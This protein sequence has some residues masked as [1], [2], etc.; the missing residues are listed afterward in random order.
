MNRDKDK[1]LAH[2]GHTFERRAFEGLEWFSR[3]PQVVGGRT[4]ELT[5]RLRKLSLKSGKLARAASRPMSVAVFGASQAG[6]SFMTGQ[7]ISPTK[8]PTKVVF[9]SGSETTTMDYGTRINPTGGKET[10]G[11]VTRFS[12]QPHEHPVPAGY[13]VV[14]KMLREVDLLKILANTHL[15]DCKAQWE[16]GKRL[17]RASIDEMLDRVDRALGPGDA[18]G[19][20]INEVYELR[21]YVENDLEDHPLARA[22][23]HSRADPDEIALCEVYWSGVERLASRAGPR[24]R[25]TLFGALWGELAEFTDLFLI[26]KD[27][28]DRLNHPEWGYV[29]LDTVL[30]RSYGV[31]HAETLYS[32]DEAHAATLEGPALNTRRMIQVVGGSAGVAV[33]LPQPVVTALTL[34]LRLTLEHAPW[35]F[36]AH[37]DFLDF[38]GARSRENKNIE[39]LLRSPDEKKARA[40]C[41]L[42]G[43]VA[44]LFDNYTADLEANALILME[45]DS[46][47]EVKTLAQLVE[48]WI[49]K[50]H[51]DTPEQRAHQP[52]S[53][54]FV[55][56]KSDTL[57]SIAGNQEGYGE[58]IRNRLTNNITKHG[59]WTRNWAPGK[60]FDNVF[61][62]RNPSFEQP[63]II[64]Y[65]SPVTAGAPLPKEGGFTVSF[66]DERPRFLRDFLASSLVQTH[67]RDPEARLNGM[68]ALND[69][70]TTLLAESLKPVCDPDLKY[71]QI[72]PPMQQIREELLALISPHFEGGDVDKRVAE[73]M[74]SIKPIVQHFVRNQ[75]SVGPFI[76]QLQASD[77]EM[78][79]CYLAF[80]HRQAASHTAPLAN[81]VEDDLMRAV[82]GG[83]VDDAQGPPAA[84]GF[85]A[86]AVASWRNCVEDI[87][88]D[89]GLA[90]GFALSPDHVANVVRE[91]LGAVERAGVEARIDAM[92]A[93]VKATPRKPE[94]MAYRIGMYAASII[95][96]AV[97]QL[98]GDPP[99]APS[100]AP[101]PRFPALPAD[102]RE[103]YSKRFARATA[104][105][106]ALLEATELNARG[107]KGSVVSTEEN[108][109]LGLIV[110]AIAG[111]V[112]E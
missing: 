63:K 107:G 111:E 79:A 83:E 49:D 43:K 106:R 67:V 14:L 64:E 60:A 85:G 74:A 105:L 76:R 99:P 46:Q 51:G 7:M 13:P 66:T 5:R 20:T 57:F 91:V 77:S 87:A 90:T 4:P 59:A 80:E 109:Q 65:E 73:R 92:V 112:V 55:V 36:F 33:S 93:D 6:K 53:M 32:M 104:W 18:P 81:D 110:S 28:L 100:A 27:A 9:S 84:A 24:E 96:T 71:R 58:K 22:R 38:P 3:N 25:A 94:E 70:G 50:T 31:L 26:L 82:F 30:D 42:R 34:E 37:T 72:V 23:E 102:P 11:L 39:D 75:A 54:F 88:G 78:C 1:K 97:S 52:V 103:N 12:I 19:M 35:D 86:A 68:L 17:D 10:T 44:V 108:A 47:G 41:F 8:R 56:S 98:S 21:E 69:G 101:P 2:A 15:Y 40:H 45:D 48:C 89:A 29:P 61:F 62:F 16:N 95:N